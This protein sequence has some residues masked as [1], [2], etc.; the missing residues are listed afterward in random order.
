MKWRSSRAAEPRA[1]SHAI[2]I[3]PGLPCQNQTAARTGREI[4]ALRLTARVARPSGCS[5]AFSSAFQAACR[6]AA[7][8]TRAS[9]AGGTGRVYPDGNGGGLDASTDSDI[10][11]IRYGRTKVKAQS[12]PASHLERHDLLWHG[13]HPRQPLHRYRIARRPFPPAPQTGRG[14]VEKCSL[15]PQR[16]KGHPVG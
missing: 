6:T 8:R 16:R 10:L 9:T 3:R 2:G 14:S 4:A 15:V 13:Q 5:E 11:D 1:T 7:T 12:S